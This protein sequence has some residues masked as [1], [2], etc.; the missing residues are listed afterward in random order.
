MVVHFGRIAYAENVF[1]TQELPVGLQGASRITVEVIKRVVGSQQRIILGFDRDPAH[2]PQGRNVGP[3]VVVSERIGVA[4][5]D[6]FRAAN[7][8]R[9]VSFQIVERVLPAR[10]ASPPRPVGGYERISHLGAPSNG[11]AE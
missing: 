5:N 7:I 11:D 8:E 3:G 6:E 2:A 4:V 1:P 10:S 9:G